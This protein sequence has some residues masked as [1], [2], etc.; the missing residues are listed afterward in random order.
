MSWLESWQL[1]LHSSMDMYSFK[2]SQGHFKG[3]FK[4]RRNVFESLFSS[5]FFDK[6]SMYKDLPCCY[7]A[8]LYLVQIWFRNPYLPESP[9]KWGLVGP[10]KNPCS[11]CGTKRSFDLVQM[12][13]TLVIINTYFESRVIYKNHL[14]WEYVIV[15]I[16]NCMANKRKD[17]S[18]MN[19]R[20]RA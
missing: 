3:H 12:K 10:S 14:N 6:L 4:L 7:D 11:E 17:K 15:I 19:K 16:C 8:T 1:F 9:R 20:L 13:I 18:C 2:Y 5:L